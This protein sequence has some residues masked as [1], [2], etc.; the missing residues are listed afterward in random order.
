MRIDA[1]TR[2]MTIV[3]TAMLTFQ[4]DHLRPIQSPARVAFGQGRA[5]WLGLRRRKPYRWVLIGSLGWMLVA[6]NGPSATPEPGLSPTTVA[7]AQVSLPLDA[8]LPT[9]EAGERSA[10][11][12]DLLVRDCLGHFGLQWQGL[13][14]AELGHDRLLQEGRLAGRFG[15][16][17]KRQAAR[18]GYHPPPWSPLHPDAR[19]Q[20]TDRDRGLLADVR[21]VLLGTTASYAGRA[22]P[23]G[24]CV[25]E[26]E[27]VLWPRPQWDGDPALVSK[28]E[29]EAD[30][31]ADA[32]PRK[33]DLFRRWSR[34]MRRAGFGYT[35]PRDAVHDQRWRRNAAGGQPSPDEI[36][37]AII[38]VRCKE[39]VRYLE[40][41]A[42]VTAE[43]QRQLINANAEALHRLQHINQTRARGV[44]QVLGPRVVTS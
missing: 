21:A 22:V 13:S 31:R 28:L 32:D 11:A 29:H 17:D 3:L 12:R 16:V 7:G 4:S 38:D 2:P 36:A 27:R 35:V 41:A 6:C 10:R 8:Y 9:A 18:Y 39:E 43:Y 23:S 26:A 44:D 5:R 25:Q 34:C 15:L 14:A 19:R 33:Q 42:A 1:Y 30:A 40:I 24:G 20:P 37:A